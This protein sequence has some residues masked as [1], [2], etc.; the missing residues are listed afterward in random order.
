[1]PSLAEFNAFL[2]LFARRGDAESAS[3]VIE[4]MKA[5][6]VQPDLI[7]YSTLIALHAY[8]R[9]AVTAQAVWEDMRL[10]GI[11]PDAVVLSTLINAYVEAGNWEAAADIWRNID[12]GLRRHHSVVGVMLKG[13][14]LLSAPHED[15]VR[16]FREAYPD[17]ASADAQAWALAIQSA[18]DS[19]RMDIA[20]ELYDEMV[21][22]AD[23][24]N[25][26]LQVTAYVYSILIAGYVRAKDVASVQEVLTEMEKRK[27]ART[28]VTEAIIIKAMADGIW[29]GSSVT[30]EQYAESLIENGD[31][32]TDQA[33]K[34]R[35]S[36]VENVLSP[37]IVKNAKKMNS[38]SAEHYFKRIV[39]EGVQPTFYMY[40][41]LLDAFR[42]CGDLDGLDR[43]WKALLQ[44]AT[45]VVCRTPES[46]GSQLAAS[47][48]NMLCIPL[49]IYMDGLTAA[50]Q[51]TKVA[52]AWRNVA[53]LGFPLMLTTGIISL[54]LW[55]ELGRWRRPFKSL[56]RCFY[57]A[58]RR[59]CG[60]RS[61]RGGR[62]SRNPGKTRSQAEFLWMTPP[63]RLLMVTFRQ[64][65]RT[66][67]QTVVINTG[68]AAETSWLGN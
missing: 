30:T 32:L 56:K 5:A 15:V 54:S 1:M 60:G 52:L 26:R 68:V 4:Q 40:T 53:E 11:S 45:E 38:A 46:G 41:T 8:R 37:L 47:Q 43:I 64:I 13:L 23:L 24:P 12:E 58:T 63:P 67:R 29:P 39:A 9:D 6:G 34:S 57:L 48:R 62:P 14:V 17:S 2:N 33:P 66:G 49:S 25:S 42:R 28:S 31:V 59:S 10:A 19:G 65:L 44:H 36:A 21:T 27:V 61:L 7:S 20:L 55:S 50:C 51:H 3:Q 16:V 35:G 18:C 22:A